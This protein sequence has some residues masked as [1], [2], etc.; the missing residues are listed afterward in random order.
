MA[1]ETGSPSEGDRPCCPECGSG[2]VWKD[3]LRY[4]KDGATVQR[5]LCQECAYRFSD[6][7]CYRKSRCSHQSSR[8]QNF[9]GLPLKVD[10]G[11]TRGCQVGALSR[12][13]ARNLVEV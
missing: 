13:R 9:L 3:G 11:L 2:K 10:D 8:G 4:L 1:S 7:S 6:P 12:K 5:W